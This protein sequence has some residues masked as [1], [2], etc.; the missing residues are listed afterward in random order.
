[1]KVW[2]SMLKSAQI[3]DLYNQQKQCI[4]AIDGQKSKCDINKIFKKL[5]ILKFSDMIK[6]E[7]SKMGYLLQTDGLPTPIM[8]QFNLHGGLK[9]H[10]YPTRYKNL[11]NIQKHESKLMNQSFMCKSITTYMTL[12]LDV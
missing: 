9:T 10:R 6:L 8:Q 3:T 5:N 4:R 7:M 12:P 2:G 11:P 1:M